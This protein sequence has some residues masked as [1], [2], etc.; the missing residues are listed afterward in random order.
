MEC[1]WV[2]YVVCEVVYWNLGIFVLIDGWLLF[3]IVGYVLCIWKCEV[4][5]FVV[6][7]NWRLVIKV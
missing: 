5:D 3:D 4:M 2:L 7:I 1:I 6:V